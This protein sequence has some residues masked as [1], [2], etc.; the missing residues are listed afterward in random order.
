MAALATLDEL[1]K[2]SLQHE[3]VDEARGSYPC[4]DGDQST[5]DRARNRLQ[6]IGMDNGEVVEPGTG[7]GSDHL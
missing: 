5:R 7:F 6:R 3:V 4:G 1:G 2:H